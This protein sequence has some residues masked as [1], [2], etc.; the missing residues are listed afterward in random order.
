[1]LRPSLTHIEPR[2]RVGELKGSDMRRLAGTPISANQAVQNYRDV[3]GQLG[4]R[5]GPSEAV[6]TVVHDRWRA[7]ELGCSSC[8]NLVVVDTGEGGHLG[9][10][11]GCLAGDDPARLSRE[12]PLGEPACC[13]SWQD[14][15]PNKA[16]PLP[17][18]ELF[19]RDEE[20]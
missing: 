7:L 11:L 20:L 18:H 15:D 3:S 6:L 17:T 19:V 10:R 16:Q 8:R 5:G 12:T 9:T 14:G 2:G 13:E 4:K 1:M